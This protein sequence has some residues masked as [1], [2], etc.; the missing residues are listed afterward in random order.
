MYCKKGHSKEHSLP[1]KSHKDFIQS[2]TGLLIIMGILFLF[3]A[4]VSQAKSNISG[5]KKIKKVEQSVIKVR[6]FDLS[7]VRLLDGPF[8]QRMLM[9]EK[10]MLELKPDRLLAPYRK[11]AGLKP[12]GRQYGGW[13]STELSGAFG[14]QYLSGLSLMYAATGNKKL[15]K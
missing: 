8:K 9:D 14:G 15:K 2:V 5:K 7:D 10:Y 13:E 3:N 6:P 12:K 11:A 4:P 1:I